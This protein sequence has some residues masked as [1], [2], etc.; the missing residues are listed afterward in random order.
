M[1][2]MPS[3]VKDVVSKQKPLPIATS[4]KNGKPNVVFVT[5]WKI[6]DDETILIVDNFMKKTRTN[7]EVN[8]N[9]AIVAYDSEIKRSFQLKGNVDLETRGDRYAIAEEMA[10]AKN[11]PAKVV[12]VFHVK[13]I[14]DNSPGPNAGN[15]LA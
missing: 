6:L 15:K 2:K 4:D 9:M 1:V 11:R 8:P 7:L 5:M 13:E 3:E 14:F 12:V 10:R